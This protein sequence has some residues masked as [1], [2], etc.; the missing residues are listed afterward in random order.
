MAPQQTQQNDGIRDD[1]KQ[2]LNALNQNRTDVT[3][4]IDELDR[5]LSQQNQ[6]VQNRF[7]ELRRELQ[8]MFVA[9]AEF[10]PKHDILEQRIAKIEAL[11]D[12]SRP[13]MAEYE[14]VKAQVKQNADELDEMTK[15]RQGLPG[16]I[17]PFITVAIAIIT[18]I[19]TLLQHVQVK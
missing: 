8:Q 7:E 2:L 14:A 18:V 10:T 3:G 6:F 1:L 12:N 17:I 16:R 5:K 13:A 11:V 9:K 19:L 15:N 4:R